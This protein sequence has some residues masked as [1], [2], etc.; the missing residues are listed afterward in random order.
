MAL[1]NLNRMA[2]FRHVTPFYSAIF[3]L[4][5]ILSLS[6]P[7]HQTLEFIILD[8]LQ[9]YCSAC[10]LQFMSQPALASTLGIPCSTLQQ[11][12]LRHLI[13]T[14]ASPHKRP[15]TSATPPYV[16]RSSAGPPTEFEGGIGHDQSVPDAPTAPAQ[17]AP[18]ATQ[19]ITNNTTHMPSSG[20]PPM[21]FG[22][23]Q[24]SAL[25]PTPFIATVAP[26]ADFILD[27]RHDCLNLGCAEQQ[28][29][30]CSH[31]QARRCTKTFSSKY[32]MGDNLKA[33]CGAAIRV[34][35]L[36]RESGLPLSTD[37]TS[38]IKLEIV[39]L[40]AK[41]V[42]FTKQ[43]GS[44][45]SPAELNAAMVPT[46]QGRP[47]LQSAFEG[48]D[49][50]SLCCEYDKEGRAVLPFRGAEVLLSGLMVTGSSEAILTGQRPQFVLLARAIDASSGT[51]IPYVPPLFSEGFVVATARVRTA[52]KKDIPHCNDP[53][54]KLNALGKATQEKL[55]DLRQA[56]IDS[57]YEDMDLP[58][59]SVT[60]VAEF[61]QLVEWAMQSKERIKALKKLL[62]LT[63]GWDEAV[64]H[65]ATAVE[66][67]TLLRAWW[68]GGQG[69]P[70]LVFAANRGMPILD[71]GPVGKRCRLYVLLER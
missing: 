63:R 41:A 70:A 10:I 7:T 6:L 42:N 62:K 71:G 55:R 64:E 57:G 52:V 46:H 19:I 13:P 67:D 31:A 5:N 28:C 26:R 37:L 48:Q 56:A 61:R 8:Y 12:A 20:A 39:L 34:V 18:P 29:Q 16:Q 65:A 36:D 27:F 54:S 2:A 59:R 35:A 53:V 38:K 66:D 40:N 44:V 23:Q 49:H 14:T 47:L 45:L 3:F 60:T 24:H 1:H 9:A 15:V 58:L 33:S 30:L 22:E 11:A 51:A 4:R 21:V 50:A 32:L 17:E 25:P 43:G 69:A 68:G